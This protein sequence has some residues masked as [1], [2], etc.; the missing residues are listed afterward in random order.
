MRGLKNPL[1]TT[2]VCC[3]ITLERVVACLLW[4][5]PSQAATFP[6]TYSLSWV[7][8]SRTLYCHESPLS[9]LARILDSHPNCP[10]LSHPPQTLYHSANTDSLSMKMVRSKLRSFSKRVL[11]KLLVEL[12]YY[13]LY[14]RLLLIVRGLCPLLYCRMRQGKCRTPKHGALYFVCFV[15]SRYLEFR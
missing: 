7:R 10:A 13:C 4:A 6:Y 5:R 3:C 12:Y 11:A 2:T 9:L 14:S 8:Y 15:V 1:P